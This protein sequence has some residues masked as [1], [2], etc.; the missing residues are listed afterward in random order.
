MK[1]LRLEELEQDPRRYREVADA[2]REGGLV[3]FP[4]RGAYRIAADLTSERA[5]ARLIQSKRRTA[6]APA[7]V[8]VAN[9][10]MLAV[11]AAEI[12]EPARTLARRFWPGSVTLLFAAH[13]DLPQKVVKPLTKANG[14][15]GVRV[16]ANVVARRI[17]SEFGGPLL[18]SSANVASKQGSASPAQV[19]KNFMGKVDL[20]VDAGDLV[21]SG[22][23]TVVWVEHQ[24]CKVTRPGLISAEEI[25]AVAGC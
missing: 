19:R 18:I 17:V 22:A 24:A 23:S 13:P 25:H 14:R 7:L 6:K 8:F 9:E 3:C 11:V 2:L 5:V 4:A 15:L 21:P 10:A 12:P 1:I 16:P 20:F